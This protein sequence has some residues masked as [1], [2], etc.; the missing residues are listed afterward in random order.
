MSDIDEKDIIKRFEAVSEFK[1]APEIAARDIARVREGLSKQDVGRGTGQQSMWR[2]IMKSRMTKLA[3][4][5]A[6]IGAV[7]I[8]ITLLDK[9]V[10]PAWAIEETTAA[11]ENVKTIT[12]SGKSNHIVPFGN[13]NILLKRNADNWDSFRVRFESKD[14]VFIINDNMWYEHT[15]GC[16]EIYA[17]D[18]EDLGDF[19]TKVWNE[20]VKNAPWII[21]IAP[22][23]LKAAK[24]V[25]T[26][27]QETYGKYGEEEQT[28]RDCVFVSGGYKPLS[29]SFWIVFDLESKLIVRTKY[30]TNPYRNGIPAIEIKE[31][32]YNEEVPDEIFDLEK[33]TGAI[34]VNEE[35]AEKR[36]ALFRQANNLASKTQ[37][38]ES[39]EVFSQLYEKY[40]QFINTPVALQYIGECYRILGQHEKAIEF[41]EKVLREYS[42]PKNA[43]ADA[44]RLLGCSYMSI[45][46]NNKALE[47][48][49]MCL[50]FIRQW[51]P[52]G[53]HYRESYR[54]QVEENIEKLKNKNR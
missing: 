7:F 49:E 51:D 40:P 21:P 23:M 6:I 29:A 30:W 42:A 22:T 19:G 44:Y 31:I 13:F 4:A 38:R 17:K 52:E 33:S 47:N 18:V 10:T 9:S 26:D 45:E 14:V 50:E 24:L 41:F 11:L 25:S 43:M 3:A 48:F 35:E 36:W 39:I 32:R 53:I 27:W 54:K 1:A 34:V 37:Y 20:V 2:T 46:Q 8:G 15:L 28:R 5:A 12:V 16:G